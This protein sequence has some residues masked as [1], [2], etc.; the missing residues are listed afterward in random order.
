MFGA[1]NTVVRIRGFGAKRRLVLR[2]DSA[3]SAKLLV[4]PMNEIGNR[5]FSV[6]RLPADNQCRG[7]NQDSFS[8]PSDDVSP[9]ALASVDS[10]A[11][12]TIR[13]GPCSYSGGNVRIADFTDSAEANQ[14]LRS[15]HECLAPSYG[16][17]ALKILGVAALYLI[18][19]TP[20][21]I[22]ARHARAARGVNSGSVGAA[23]ATKPHQSYARPMLHSMNAGAPTHGARDSFGL[24]LN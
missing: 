14:A 12:F 8:E 20:L 11:R 3:L 7:E 16:R 22:G 9:D 10:A 19:T 4:L 5:L 1:N 2:F 23:S 13:M 24:K 17:L 21:P 6:D 15:I 18:L